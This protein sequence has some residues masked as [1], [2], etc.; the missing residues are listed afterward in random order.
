MKEL[1]RTRSIELRF[2]RDLWGDPEE[3]ICE[4]LKQWK[5]KTPLERDRLEAGH[6]GVV[7]GPALSDQGL[8]PEENQ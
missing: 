5:K 4:P 8:N 1:S 7:F 2:H 6:W 3:G